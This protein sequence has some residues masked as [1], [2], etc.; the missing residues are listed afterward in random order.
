ME[1]PL[2]HALEDA[3]PGIDNQERL[4]GGKAAGLATMARDLGLPVPP[5]FVATTRV[6]HEFLARGWQAELDDLLRAHLE[7]LATKT[8]RR[9]GDPVAPLLVS[10]RSGAPVSMPG[11]MD[12]LLNVGMTPRIRE[13]LAEESG[14][15]EFAADT[16][17][18]FNRMYAEIVLELPREQLQRAA[19]HDGSE[20][21][22]LGAAERIR[23]LAIG[24][25]G[26]PGEPFDQLRGAIQAVF[27]SWMSERA[28]VFREKEG[29][30]ADLGTAATVQAMAFGNLDDLSG[31][32]VAFTRDPATGEAKPCG[33]YLAR[34][35]GEDVVAGSHKVLGLE[36]LA[37][38]LPAVHQELLS[39]LSRLEHH[40][41]DMC[42]VE[43][44][45]SAGKLYL[46]QT[47]VGR[48]SPLAAVRIAVSMAE[49][50]GFPLSQNEAVDR[51]GE[52]TL[53]EL[54]Q[55]GR[56]KQHATPIA[57]GLAVS[58]GVGA[59]ALCCDSNRAAD[60]A[61][62]G[63]AVILARPE[64]SPS[65]VHGMVA[66]AGLV[67]TLGGMVSHAAVVARGWA[68]PAICSLT[69]AV[70]EADGLHAG[71]VIVHEGDTVTV[72]GTTGNLY[73][74]DVRED[75][76]LDL[77]EV[78]KLRAWALEEESEASVEFNEATGDVTPFELLR[79]LQLKGLC[80]VERLAAA[81]A[82]S[83][84]TISEALEPHEAFLKTTPRGFA[85]T[86]EGRAWVQE[87]LA[88]EHAS[89]E[90][91][92]EP[93]WQR[94]QPL[95]H[96]LKVLVTETQMSSINP[97]H[98]RW[99]WLMESMASLHA[100]FRPV[101]DEVA[102]MAPRLRGYGRR[103]D[104]ALAALSAGDASMLASPLKDSYHTVWFE[105]HEEFI[106][107]TGRNREDEERAASH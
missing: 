29:I 93:A 103:F 51:V 78:R 96:Q 13:R 88:E 42:D 23:G 9:F 40:Y 63:R 101:V 35:Q 20:Q 10:V 68:I 69:N 100:E 26:I 52:D 59:G 74:G 43:F 3:L 38:Q 46:L 11:M 48:R 55:L 1:A 37:Q 50:P 107:L 81:L 82:C 41:R 34:A 102:T 16:W 67:T 79:A 72:D 76:G 90:G 75:A 7:R 39:V 57:W 31:T 61:A 97:E 65:D 2:V 15:R 60:W 25:G 45:V 94:F 86:P 19:E 91:D 87:R 36:A 30:S 49:D 84:E 14:N 5:G 32:G 92:L 104:A 54:A 95:N 62:N 33:D 28:I 73:L 6:C 85:L 12:T 99:G 89:V 105:F 71:S 56:V 64:T 77:P 53:R 58:P 80:S 4:L 21:S 70:V 44:T 18:R 27:R 66:S 47:R 98:E 24:A 83:E 106:A 22:M 8:G 17:L